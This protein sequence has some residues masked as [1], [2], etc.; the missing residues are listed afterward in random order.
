MNL[1]ETAVMYLVRHGATAANEQVP[2]ILQGD[3]LNQPLN[4]NGE[5]QAAA[6]GELL[7]AFPLVAV[8]CSPLLRAMQ[9]A[10][11]IAGHHQL[12]PQPIDAL[13]EVNVGRWESLDWGTI[14]QRFPEEHRAFV[15]NP[16]DV[17]RLGGESDRDVL[18]RV[19]GVFSE[20]LDR[21]RGSRFAVV[22][23]NVVNRV[24]TSSLLEMDLRR[25]QRIR[26]SNGGIN[27]IRR[28][29][30]GTDVLCVNSVFHVAHLP[31][32]GPQ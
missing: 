8:Y 13:R 9:T 3:G 22:A 15:D 32:Y 10:R 20:L 12:Q 28:W 4:A 25:T 31:S 14:Q 18:N 11:A 21:H 26:Q 30:A 7:K 27:I 6:T 1:G 19:Q 23:H 17:P 2:F 24:Y 16:A 5:A 29:N